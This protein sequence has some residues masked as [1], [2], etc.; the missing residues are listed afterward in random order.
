M[1]LL[2]PSL[3]R[4]KKKWKLGQI[5]KVTL[6]IHTNCSQ[7]NKHQKFK[8]LGLKSV[9]LKRRLIYPRK[10]QAK[11]ELL[12]LKLIHLFAKFY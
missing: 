6:V 5:R 7:K 8:G 9:H 10:V 11:A 12:L 1:T 3:F 2:E 4:I